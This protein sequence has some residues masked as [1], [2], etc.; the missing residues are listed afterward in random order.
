MD[1]LIARLFLDDWKRKLVA[2][3]GAIAVWLFVHQSITETKTLA[4]VPIRLIN[5][6]SNKTVQGLLP[7]GL[8]N[9]RVTLTIMGTKDIVDGLESS[10][11][12]VVIDAANLP[13]DWILQ[14]NKKNLVSLDPEVD[15]SHHIT[16]V[17]NNEFVV[18]M[19]TLITERVPI[20]ISP[21]LGSAPEGYEF[22]DFRPQT[23]F[24]MVTGPEEIVRQLEQSGFPLQFD[25]SQIPKSQLDQIKGSETTFRQDEVE[26]PVPTKWKTVTLPFEGDVVEA[27]NDPAAKNMA[28]SFLRKEL[29]PIPT[30][31]PVTVYYPIENA[32]TI[33][34]QTYA[35]ATNDF[36]K[37]RDGIK[38]LTI[39]LLAAEVSR[40]FIDVVKD[41][42]QL[43]IVAAKPTEREFLQ[44]TIDFINER[45]LEDTFVA[46]L[47]S[48]GTEKA[49]AKK[50]EA[51][52]RRRFREYIQSIVVYKAK[53]QKLVLEPTLKDGAVKV[54]D[55]SGTF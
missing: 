52:L 47:M 51:R 45:E 49:Q 50:Q 22:L 42:V 39:P 34:P 25:L 8:L 15:L 20:T 35:L 33:N 31:V 2:I 12:E 40:L 44:W 32:N 23:L 3:I 36:I 28:I 38:Y 21:P 37:D 24:Q 27:I 18:K 11:L 5:L 30:E 7:N 14:V 26:F 46:L 4:N 10:D 17:T 55:V 41:N 13:D 1:N 29:I 19:N 53:G 16:A 48:D 9:R 43:V 54:K 6:P